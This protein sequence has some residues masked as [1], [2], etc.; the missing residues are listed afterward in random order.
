MKTKKKKPKT[1]LGHDSSVDVCG[2]ALKV[3]KR[4]MLLTVSAP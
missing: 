2:K 3:L 1:G 4:P